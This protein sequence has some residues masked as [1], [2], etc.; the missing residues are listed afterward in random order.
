[1]VPPKRQVVHGSFGTIPACI[2]GKKY[3]ITHLIKKFSHA[4]DP[5]QFSR[6][7]EMRL[8]CLTEAQ[9][10]E[11]MN[12]KTEEDVSREQATYDMLEKYLG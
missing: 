12:P 1:M 5:I 10:K 7:M 9:V 8:R 3:L 4:E 6:Q 2:P 11:I